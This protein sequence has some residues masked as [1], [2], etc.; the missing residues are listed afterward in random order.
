MNPTRSELIFSWTPTTLVFGIALV[1]VVATLS[2][3]I[4][5]RSG[6]TTAVAVSEI[7]RLLIV[8]AVAITLNQ[9]EWREIR[10]PDQKPSLVV[11]RDDSGSMATE[12]AGKATDGK[13]GEGGESTAPL[14]RA[15][16]AKKL[17]D[18]ELWEPLAESHEVVLQT[19]SAPDA[20]GTDIAT[21]LQETLQ[22]HPH[23]GA[24]VLISDGDWNLGDSPT[25]AA[26]RYRAAGVPVFTLP[27]GSET[28]L[29]DLAVISFSPPTFAIV[30]KPVVLPFAVKSTLPRDHSAQLELRADE[31]SL[32][33]QQISLPAMGR[34][35]NT[36]RWVPE[37]EGDYELSLSIESVPEERDTDNNVQTARL[38]V[39][40]ESL[41]VLVV[42]TFPRWEYRYLRN[43]L[44]RDP[45]VE[46]HCLLFHPDG[47]GVGKGPGYLDSF[48]SQEDL[49]S[50]DVVFLGDV[51]VTQGQLTSEQATH[52][53]HAVS[54][55]ATGLVFLP[56]FRGYELSLL[57]SDLRDLFPVVMDTAQVRGW[58][59]ATPGRLD[60]TELG[61]KSL[62]T[63]LEDEDAENTRVWNS[64]PG[65][66][67]HAGV[68]RAAAGSEVLAIHSTETN[69]Y[70]RLPLI[71][72]KTFGAGKILFMGTDGAWRWRRGVEDKYHYRY[73]GQVV[74]WMA[75]QRNMASG[76]HL[77][78]FYSPD[79][80]R[81]GDTLS[82]NA[83]AMS[84]SGEPLQAAR[85]AARIA[86][87]SDKVDTVPFRPS[88]EDQWGLFT[89]T[90]TPTEPGDHRIT[91][92]CVE[93]GETLETI[94]TVQGTPRE[95]V[96][97]PARPDVLDEIA[98][99]TRGEQL[100][101]LD[102]AQL[103]QRIAEL[104]EP[105]PIEMRLRLWA[106]PYWIGAIFAM[107]TAF[108][109]A[110]KAAGSV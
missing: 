89:A 67:W 30:G 65:F 51:G 45:G 55:Q 50:Y 46:V 96:G 70:G 106:S 66:Q 64:L 21:A 17:T 95:R 69:R 10:Q 107:L 84:I 16:V 13:D 8:V 54:A 18:P 23:L 7:L 80:P 9:P 100:T 44:E 82:L 53:R 42:E 88:D 4:W 19:F 104:P 2:F 29:P 36:L 14:S 28:P 41:R 25:Q 79:R 77:R 102:P 108:W 49:S 105:P 56:G 33:K 11:L 101:A 90:Y 68:L 81:V 48:P 60:L 22:T 85:V 61:S 98:R 26:M 103:I 109:I 52:L 24:A 43:A 35:E 3:L 32:V 99:I 20:E 71:V 1:L 58:G 62:L 31:L 75:Y 40:K 63:R 87:A 6:K 92:H 57:D 38:S 15:A 83:N 76:A 39:R 86:T 47:N 91:L 37:K 78:L 74:R 27:V 73:W 59:S 12:D 110:R 72:T 93:N 97:N 5:R 94:V 34:A